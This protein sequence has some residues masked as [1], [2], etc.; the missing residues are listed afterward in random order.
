MQD[1]FLYVIEESYQRLYLS[2]KIVLSNL[3]DQVRDNK[4]AYEIFAK[5]HPTSK[6]IFYAFELHFDKEMAE[7][8][9]L[10]I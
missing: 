9:R 10:Y 4:I 8:L 7:F 1:K 3:T 5:S 6:E 2:K